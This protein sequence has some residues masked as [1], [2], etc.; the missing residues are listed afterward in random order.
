M[1]INV[2]ESGRGT[3]RRLIQAGEALRGVA[4]MM[5]FCVLAGFGLQ[6]T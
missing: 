5:G 4:Q 1:A 2:A 3:A 6:R